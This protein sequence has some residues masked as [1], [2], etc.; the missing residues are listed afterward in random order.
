MTGLLKYEQRGVG[1]PL[2]LVHGFL[3]SSKYW[4]PQ[5]VYFEGMFNTIVPDLPGFGESSGGGVPDTLA[6]FAER[7]LQVVDQADVER[8]A[9]V[10]NSIGG[11]V[12]LQLALDYPK[13]VSKLV[14]YGTGSSAPKRRFE[15][16]EETIDRIGREG[17]ACVR[18]HIAAT[19]FVEGEKHPF[20]PLCADAGECVSAEAAVRTLRAVSKWDVTERLGE[21]S[22]PTLVISG[23]RDRST[24]P[25]DSYLLWRGIASAQLCIV[26]NCAHNVHLERPEVFNKIV[27]DFLAGERVD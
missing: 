25:E 18:R 20:F 13:R 17:L 21:L 10:G 5:K 8:F 2:V 15:T 22:V 7:V 27:F 23:D 12:A 9:L 6:E 26:P 4:L 14:L 19:W 3:S 16:I 11:S 24:A 1:K